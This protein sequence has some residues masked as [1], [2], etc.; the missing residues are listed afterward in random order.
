MPTDLLKLSGM[1]LSSEPIG[2]YDRRLVFL[3]KERGKISAFAKGARRQNSTLLAVTSPFVFA[4]F[5]FYEG[6]NSYTLKN[7]EVINYFRDLKQDLE[8]VCMASYLAEFAGYYAK[9]NL[10]EPHAL[11]LLYKAYQALEKGVMDKNLIRFVFELKLMQING[12][13]TIT[14]KVPVCNAALYAWQFVLETNIGKLF[15][16]TLTEEA[17]KDFE[18]SV[19][20]LRK[21][22]VEED[23]ASLKIMEQLK[24][25]A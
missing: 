3:T 23:F 16:F 19:T 25:R 4:D 20:Y 8:L 22:V 18:K 15:Q 2:E 13:Y 11:N 1:V 9:E 12:E 5:Y 10:Y 17:L 21:H 7:A 24:E 14:P 6:R